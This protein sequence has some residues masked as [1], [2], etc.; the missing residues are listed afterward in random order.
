MLLAGRHVL[1]FAGPLYQDLRAIKDDL[2]TLISSRRPQNIS[3][4]VRA[5]IAALRGKEATT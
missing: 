1:F 4:F 5:I 2:V 3:H